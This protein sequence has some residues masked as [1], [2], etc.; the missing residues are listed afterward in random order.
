MS[1]DA[2][3][4]V[5]DADDRLQEMQIFILHGWTYDPATTTKWQP[6][7]DLL[8]QAGQETTFLE[9]PGLLSPLEE[10]WDVPQYLTWLAETLPPEPVVL[11]GHSFGGQLAT[12]FAALYP[13]R[14]SA[15]ILI[16]SSGVRSQKLG[17]RL[18]R[19]VLGSIARVGTL[20]HL[21]TPAL[22]LVL[23]RLARER[24]YYH[25]TPIQRQTMS[26]VLTASVVERVKAV[27]A[28]SLLIWGSNDTIT[29]VSTLPVFEQIP[30][31]QVVLVPSAR[32]SPQY[33]HPEA[34]AAAI[35]EFVTGQQER[36]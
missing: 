14:V 3:W 26:Q 35:V 5:S 25:A 27:R 8:A 29:P 17:S 13:E 32:H 12:H 2:Y 24:D 28:P 36:L 31:H 30:D 11:L 18:K 19:F 21:N 22:R 1:R 6:L 16:A 23:Y 9:L 20:L 4:T 34:V 33:T 10:A 15:V 7:R